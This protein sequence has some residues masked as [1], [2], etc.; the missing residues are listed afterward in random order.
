[1]ANVK[2]NLANQL[3]IKE[4]NINNNITQ[5]TTQTR[6]S[7]CET[8]LRS[9]GNKINH[10]GRACRRLWVFEVL[11]FWS[12][13]ITSA[14]T[15]Y[16]WNADLWLSF[17]VTWWICWLSAVGSSRLPLWVT[18]L[19][20]WCRAHF[21][22]HILRTYFRYTLYFVCRA[23]ARLHIR[24]SQNKKVLVLGEF[25]H[26]RQC[27]HKHVS[28]LPKQKRSKRPLNIF[29]WLISKISPTQYNLPFSH[30]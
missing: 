16:G 27:T 8:R 12:S 29:L 28:D 21:N 2:T 11:I 19:T 20:L 3:A 6:V 9:E 1:M 22:G 25:T 26:S 5:K 17:E 24:P 13:C 7:F 14:I 18:W 23:A 10:K 30:E 15:I 4:A